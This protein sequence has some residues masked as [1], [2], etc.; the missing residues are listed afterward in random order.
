MRGHIVRRGKSSWR[1]KFDI[2]ASVGKRQTRYVT[3]R[4][5]RQDAERELA[6]LIASAGTSS[7]V[8]PSKVAVR[9]FVLARVDQWEAAGEI[10][11]RTA[12]R[13][14]QL[15]EHQIVP[16]LGNKV[17][18]KLTRLD[19]EA[20]HTTLRNDGLAPRTIGHAHRV[21]GKALS[22]AERD[23]MVVRNVCKLQ[24][25][26]LPCSASCAVCVWPRVIAQEMAIVRDVPAFVV[27]C[28]ARRRQQHQ[29]GRR[30]VS[31]LEAQPC[32]PTDPRRRGHRDHQQAL[33]AR[34]A[35]YHLAHLC[36]S[37]PERRRQG[38]CRHQRG[39]EPLGCQ[40]GAN[41]A[42]RSIEWTC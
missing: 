34:H 7:Y 32:Q 23:G 15:T 40:S 9:D 31:C 33:G 13:Y 17:L 24:K 18:Q 12:Q 37:V 1:I 25:T 29:H 10:S 35:R 42:V 30:D 14:R 11:A 4:G 36:P 41:F 26:S 8:E 6:K 38:C 28:M 19:V 3:V 39:L 2:D 16:H 20:W 27:G 5:K 21:L 22:D